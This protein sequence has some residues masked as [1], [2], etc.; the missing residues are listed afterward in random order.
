MNQI[1]QRRVI[2]FCL[3]TK[4][5]AVNE[6]ISPCRQCNRIYQTCLT[7]DGLRLKR[8]NR[9]VDK[10]AEQRLIYDY[11]RHRVSRARRRLRF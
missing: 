10:N 3:S 1:T 9:F 5:I 2:S 6:H 8:N 4:W 7:L 11:Y